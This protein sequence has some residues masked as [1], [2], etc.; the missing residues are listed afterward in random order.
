MSHEIRKTDDGGFAVTDAHGRIQ[1]MVDGEGR[2]QIGAGF[3]S[4]KDAR[5][6]AEA[7]GLDVRESG[8]SGS[9]SSGTGGGST[10]SSSRSSSSRS[11]SSR[12]SS[13]RSR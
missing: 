13:S 6:L 11:S 4:S 9:R 8:K 1:T 2:S 5:E 10:S 7:N 12:S 3:E